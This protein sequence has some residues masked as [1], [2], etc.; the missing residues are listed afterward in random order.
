MSVKLPYW[1]RDPF[2]HLSSAEK[3]RIKYAER[4]ASERLRLI[5]PN[6]EFALRIPPKI[7]G[8][9]YEP[10]SM[11]TRRKGRVYMDPNPVKMKEPEKVHRVY[12]GRGRTLRME[13]ENQDGFY[14]GYILVKTSLNCILY[15]S[16]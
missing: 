15:D 2:S 16:F 7:P 3:K 14:F 8:R 6:G 11:T 5:H 4:D 1:S 9:F 12:R 10:E 13:R